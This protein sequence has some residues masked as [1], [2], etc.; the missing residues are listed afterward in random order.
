MRLYAF[1][2]LSSLI[3]VWA[4]P[5]AS[6][7]GTAWKL[8]ENPDLTAV[9]F[10]YSDGEP[11]AYAEVL[12]YS[13]QDSEVEHQNGRTDRSGRFA[14]CPDMP[15]TWRVIAT[16]GM[17]HMCEAMVETGAQAASETTDELTGHTGGGS[18]IQGAKL[19]KMIAGFSIIFNLAFVVRFF[20][21]LARGPKRRT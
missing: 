19:L 6:A 2:V 5:N 10:H 16:D 20:H 17:G 18:S 4:T 7:H 21:R 8:L 3:L 11:M 13:P 12:V 9:A 14:F 1:F 15:G